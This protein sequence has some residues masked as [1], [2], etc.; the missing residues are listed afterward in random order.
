MSRL[1]PLALVGCAGTPTPSRSA[2]E[3]LDEVVALAQENGSEIV[4]GPFVTEYT[5]ASASDAVRTVGLEG[6]AEYL[7]IV[8][9]PEGGRLN[10]DVQVYG[11]STD[12]SFMGMSH[13]ERETLVIN[14]VGSGSY[15]V[16][17]QVLTERG[18]VDRPLPYGYV[19]LRG[20]G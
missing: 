10:P 5:D 6:G 13:G 20:D 3:V 12:E 9:T 1:F 16:E 11:P 7:L 14:P 17:V 15:L 2:G 18:F 4:A 8:V 19:I